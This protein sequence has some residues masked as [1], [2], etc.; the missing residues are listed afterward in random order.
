M[1]LSL[2]QE[3]YIVYHLIWKHPTAIKNYIQKVKPNSN[4]YWSTI[5]Y[6]E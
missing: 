5:G 3:P 6:Y 2:C 1:V 4:E